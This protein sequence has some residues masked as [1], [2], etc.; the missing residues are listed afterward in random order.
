MPKGVRGSGPYSKY[1]ED[2]T[3]KNETPKRT[4]RKRTTRKTTARKTTTTTRRRSNGAT[5]LGE[6][7]GISINTDGTLLLEKRDGSTVK[8]TLARPSIVLDLEQDV[9]TAAQAYLDEREVVWS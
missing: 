4:T 1:N 2:G 6:F 8:A 9:H 7:I 3:L 5:D